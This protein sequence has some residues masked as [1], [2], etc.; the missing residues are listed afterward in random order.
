MSFTP[1]DISNPD[2]LTIPECVAVL[3]ALHDAILPDRIFRIQQGHP[4]T[5]Q[6]WAELV[7][8]T[9][10]LTHADEPNLRRILERAKAAMS[11]K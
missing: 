8:W 1:P 11:A 10:T 4:V 5:D 3:T 2:G 6:R 9:R 7:E